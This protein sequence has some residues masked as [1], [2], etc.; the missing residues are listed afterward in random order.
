LIAFVTGYEVPVG[1]I[2]AMLPV[3]FHH[4]ATP[5]ARFDLLERMIRWDMECVLKA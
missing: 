1:T 3:H 4:D 2:L 5:A